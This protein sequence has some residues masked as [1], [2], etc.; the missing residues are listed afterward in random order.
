MI[1]NTILK[2]ITRMKPM[3]IAIMNPN[4][5]KSISIQFY[6]LAYLLMG[7]SAVSLLL[8]QRYLIF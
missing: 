7:E 1:I 3:K 2:S 4:K 8:M 5:K 6:E